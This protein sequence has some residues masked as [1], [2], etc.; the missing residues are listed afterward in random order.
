MKKVLVIGDSCVDIFE[1]GK[2]NRICP[3][4]PVPVLMPF[5][6][7]Q[8]SGM[9]SNVYVNLISLGVF[10]DIITNNN[11]PIKKRYIDEPSNQMLLRVDRYDNVDELDWEVLNKIPFNEYDAVVIS[12]YDKGFLDR[13]QI[14]YIS[15]IHPL[16]FMDSKKLLDEWC[17]DIKFIKLNE[18]ESQENWEYLHNDFPN[19]IIITLG[20]QGAK[21]NFKE[22]FPIE[23]EHPVRDLTGAGD[24]FLAGLVANYLT[25]KD[26]RKAINFA[27]KCAAWAVTQKGVAVVSIDKLKLC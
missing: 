22:K 14:R 18:K 6:I 16:T 24:T 19:D 1:Y 3:E 15:S 4:A 25:S 23:D 20:K 13:E 27:N 26:I 11:L 9:T 8:N 17:D 2:C 10:C 5:D 7:K 21:L 12:D